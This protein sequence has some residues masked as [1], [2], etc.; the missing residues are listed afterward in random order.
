MVRTHQC[1]VGTHQCMVRTYQCLPF[2]LHVDDVSRIQ[3][4]RVDRIRRGKAHVNGAVEILQDELR[5]LCSHL[6]GNV[7]E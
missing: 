3:H 1:M 7:Q 5:P 4:R 6:T 2:D